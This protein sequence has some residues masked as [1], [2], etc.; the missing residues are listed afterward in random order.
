VLFC[1]RFA[2]YHAQSRSVVISPVSATKGNIA[3][4]IAV[5]CACASLGRPVHL[6][7]QTDR[8]GNVWW[9]HG[10]KEPP[11]APPTAKGSSHRTTHG[12]LTSPSPPLAHAGG[13]RL[14][15]GSPLSPATADLGWYGRHLRSF[16]RVNGL[17]SAWRALKR[18]WTL[19][20]RWQAMTTKSHVSAATSLT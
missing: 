18:A 17:P 7:C 15:Q 4:T 2:I 1:H 14:L 9:L 12:G 20:M 6:V 11:S 13:R 10:L 8:L 3:P 19:T 16:Y 5:K